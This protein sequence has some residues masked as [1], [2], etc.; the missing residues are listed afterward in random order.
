MPQWLCNQLRKAF[1]K[2]DRRQIKL[3]NECWFFYRNAPEE[4]SDA[5]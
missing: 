2:K 5:R 3:L 1:H 4:N